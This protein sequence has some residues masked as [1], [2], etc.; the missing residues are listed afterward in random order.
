[1]RFKTWLMQFENLAGPG[2]G[3]DGQSDNPGKLAMQDIRMGVGAWDVR[4]VKSNRVNKQDPPPTGCSPC[5][6][7]LPKKMKKN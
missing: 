3:P 4:G 5:H 2:G 7:Y 1:M 6:R